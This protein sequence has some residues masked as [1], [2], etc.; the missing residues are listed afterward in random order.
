[1]PVGWSWSV[2]AMAGFAL[3]WLAWSGFLLHP[4]SGAGMNTPYVDATFHLSLIGELR[5]HFPP[6]VPWVTGE[7]VSYHW[8][9][10]A[11]MAASSWV[12]AIE[13]QVILF[14]L[15][16]IPLVVLT[17]V[18]TAILGSRISGRLWAGPVAA[19]LYVLVGSFSP[20]AWAWFG[21]SFTD[22]SLL[23][24]TLWGSPTQTY[25]MALFLPVVLLL[26]DRLR[27]EPGAGGQWLLFALVLTATVG[28]KATFLPLLLGG[29]GLAA[30]IGLIARRRIE[31]PLI[32]AGALTF[33]GFLYAQMVLFGG[34]TQG[35][36]VEPFAVLE[37]IAGTH[38]NPI[39]TWF[40]TLAFALTLLSWSARAAGVLGIM[41][42]RERWLDPLAGVLVGIV[43]VG[44]VAAFTFSQSGGGQLY[45]V[46]SVTPFIAVL[47]AWGA[48]QLLPRER[49]TRN[50][51]LVLFGTALAGAA[52]STVVILAGDQVRPHIAQLGNRREVAI[53]LVTPYVVVLAV[54]AALALALLLLR[55]RYA[56]LRGVSAVLVLAFV[57][58]LG[59]TR[60]IPAVRDPLRDISTHGGLV[61]RNGSQD[62]RPIADGGIEAASPR[63]STAARSTRASATTGT[64]GSPRSPSGGC[65]WRAGATR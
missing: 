57:F 29:I 16:A 32:I 39:P 4:L 1:M 2:A 5:H 60:L 14:R 41:S 9:V 55:R 40:L 23:L 65:S 17:V 61:Y 28:G 22:T 62:G 54:V 48:A 21:P 26:V 18:L 45:F 27:R 20:Y 8:F 7:P 12:T 47:S 33:A 56:V 35:L 51:A 10:H 49:A 50:M 34:A 37:S 31:R 58:G 11:H 52:A 3:A 44:T 38:M 36:L 42:R 63:T 15:F 13:P 25:G 24:G 59:A 46:R 43:V 53:A 30:V 19:A 6:K 64:S